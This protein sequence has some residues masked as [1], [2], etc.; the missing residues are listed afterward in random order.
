[1]GIT[2]VIGETAGHGVEKGRGGREPLSRDAIEEILEDGAGAVGR[3]VVLR[4]LPGSGK[5]SFARSL[6]E[7]QIKGVNEMVG[8]G[9]GEDGG[10]GGK[11]KM[12]G[13]CRAVICSADHFFDGVRR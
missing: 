9:G 10:M 8:W 3:V 12:G 1:V 11:G 7:A 2:G 4:G 13:G 6:A 5:S